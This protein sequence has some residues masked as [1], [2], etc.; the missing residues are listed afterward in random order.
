MLAKRIIYALIFAAIA[1][2]F[3]YFKTPGFVA[4]IFI[5]G[6]IAIYEINGALKA[7]GMESCSVFGYAFMVLMGPAYYFIGELGLFFVLGLCTYMSFCYY[8]VK[9]QV[10]SS[11]LYSLIQFIYPC[12]F[13][14]FFW[15]L[16]YSGNHPDFGFLIMLTLV[17]CCIATDVFAYFAGVYLGKH[18]LNPNVSPK[19]TIEGSV[20]GF[21]GSVFVSV[22]AH[23]GLPYI[24]NIS[25]PL[26]L[27]VLIGVACGVCSQYGDLTASMIKRVCGIKDFGN[28][29]P[30]HGGILDRVDSIMF[31]IP[32]CYFI[33]YMFDLL[34][35]I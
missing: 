30:G 7:G 25:I 15:P 19:K 27:A 9:K 13:V 5:L 32:I 24:L 1:L 34:G 4:L 35:G 6:I 3:L 23:Y 28:L 12:L 14:A 29:I 8:I 18:K 10:T 33:V 11:A 2:A 17:L 21:L 26:S 20:G 22:C 31:C 16:I